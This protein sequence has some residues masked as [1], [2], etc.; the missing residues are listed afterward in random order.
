MN[1]VRIST[2]FW[3]P[4]KTLTSVKTTKPS[5]QNDLVSVQHLGRDLILSSCDLQEN[6][7]FLLLTR[8]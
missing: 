7:I 1:H 5:T 3:W 8:C 4:Y 2:H 6:T